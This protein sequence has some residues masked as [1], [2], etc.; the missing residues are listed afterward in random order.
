MSTDPSTY[1]FNHT[2]LRVKDPKVSLKFYVEVLGMKLLHQ[3][4]NEAGKFTLYFLAYADDVPTNKEEAHAAAFSR[5]G[6][7]ELTHNWG[8]ESDPSFQGYHN[9][10]TAPQ[11]FGHIAV[12][13]DN[14]EAACARFDTM[15]VSWKKRVHEGNMK[16]IAFLLDP[17]GYWIEILESGFPRK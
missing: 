17:D 5:P 13:V 7:L 6:V 15:G 14:L 8:T 16:N 2:M 11:G 10:N 1:C 4:D 12:V 9:G 3:M